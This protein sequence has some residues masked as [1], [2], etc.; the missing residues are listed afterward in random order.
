MDVDTTSKRLQDSNILDN[1]YARSVILEGELYTAEM[2]A[3]IGNNYGN[4]QITF[5][6][7]K[8]IMKKKTC[9]QQ[10]VFINGKLL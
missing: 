1:V 2:Q 3:A 4:L 5:N 10:K 9:Q 7:F 6:N 8:S